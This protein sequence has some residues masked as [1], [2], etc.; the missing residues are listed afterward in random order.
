MAHPLKDQAA[1]VG[2]G[3]RLCGYGHYHERYEKRDDRLRISAIR[4]TRLRVDME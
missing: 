4:L 1:V 2:V 3:R